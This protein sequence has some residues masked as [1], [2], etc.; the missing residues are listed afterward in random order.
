MCY[1]DGRIEKLVKSHRLL[2][3]VC[4]IDH[5]HLLYPFEDILSTRVSQI[6]V[7]YLLATIVFVCTMRFTISRISDGDIMNLE[8]F[9]VFEYFQN[10]Y[11]IN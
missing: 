2:L 4:P 3:L 7:N 8:I 1:R 10:V 9:I 6:L 11:N 5:R